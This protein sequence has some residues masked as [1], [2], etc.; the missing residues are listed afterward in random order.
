[1][2]NRAER[3]RMER[4]GRK[5]G[6][7]EVTEETKKAVVDAINR[8]QTRDEAILTASGPIVKAIYAGLICVLADEYG[9]TTEACFDVLKSLD[10]KVIL[11][12]DSDE[13]AEEA[14]RKTGIQLNLGEAFERVM[15]RVK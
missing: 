6:Y 9:F 7:S 1:M 13:I 2:P 3:R 11:C 12:L 14:L 15:K 5:N 10:D 4:E 8:K